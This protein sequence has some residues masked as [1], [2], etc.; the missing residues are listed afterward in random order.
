MEKIDDSSTKESGAATTAAEALVSKN[1]GAGKPIPPQVITVDASNREEE[2]KAAANSASQA[3]TPKHANKTKEGE[4]SATTIDSQKNVTPERSGD[5]TRATATSNTHNF[6]QPPRPYEGRPLG[7]SGAFQPH[8]SR[9][10]QQP[11]PHQHGGPPPHGQPHPDQYYTRSPMQISPGG[12]GAFERIGGYYDRR[13]PGGYPSHH[14]P[15]PPP[16]YYDQRGYND[17]GPPPPMPRPPPHMQAFEQ[18]Q[19]HRG[20]Y[21]PPPYPPQSYTGFQPD[22]RSAYGGH[23]PQAYPPSGPGQYPPG[24][25]H[26]ARDQ[27]YPQEHHGVNSTFSRAVSSSFDR[28]VKEKIAPPGKLSSAQSGVATKPFS[29]APPLAEHAPPG[30]ASMTSDDLSWKQLKQVHSIDDSAIQ[31]HLGLKKRQTPKD[32]DDDEEDGER[33]PPSNSSSLTN[34]PTEGPVR[35]AKVAEAIVAAAAAAAARSQET[36]QP[37]SSSL[38]E[39]SSVASAQAPMDTLHSKSKKPGKPSPPSPGTE[40]SGSLDLMKCS[41]DSSALLQLAAHRNEG[42]LF[43]GKRSRDE[44]RGDS[45]TGVGTEGDDTAELRRA[46]SDLDEKQPLKKVR[47]ERKNDQEDDQARTSKITGTK[48]KTSPLSI[49]CSPSATVTKKSSDASLKVSSAAKPKADF[50][51]SP[52][53]ENS[54]YDKPPAYSYSLDSAPSI[55]RDNGFKRKQQASPA[56]PPRP[57]S[58]S[59]SSLT[60]GHMQIDNQDP[61]NAVVASIPSWEIHAQDSFGAG[62]VGGGHGLANN[63]SF[64]DY[65]MLSASESNLGNAIETAGAGPPHVPVPGHGHGGVPQ[66][67]HMPHP[68]IESRNQSFDGGH[69]HG[70]GS[71]HRSDSMDMSYNGRPGGPGPGPVYPEGPYKHGHVGPFPPHAP[72]WGTAGSGGSHPSYQGHPPGHHP[73]PGRMGE[74]PIM[75]N[76]S[77]DSGHRASPPPGPGVPGRHFMHRPPAG[78]Q[79]PPEFVAPHNPHLNRRPPPA[80]YIMS[81]QGTHHP[82]AQRG[83]G[84]FSWS[85]ED[86]IRL[87]EIMKKYKNPRDWEPVAKELGTG[88]T[89][90]ECHERWI[91]YLKPGVRKGQWTDQEDAIVIEAVTTSSEQPFTRW[92]DL[93]QRLPGRVGKQIRDR[94]VNHL[95]PNINHLPFSREDDLLLWDGHKKLG[96]R[97]VEISTKFFNCSRSE[98]HIK[99][100]WYSASF[101]KFISNEFGQEAYSGGKSSKGKDGSSGKKKTKK[102]D[103]DP[104]THAVGA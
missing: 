64:Q 66:H 49:T 6:P 1:A 54:F 97:W 82:A 74:Y 37:P 5:S 80:V 41:S 15:P 50:H 27:G 98:N 39:L 16:A 40:D 90:K 72:S 103:D 95:N 25:D 20:Q 88:K 86:D 52:Y 12:P 84:V 48:T 55:P 24:P 58:S 57:G 17:Y 18:H 83:T 23:A 35:R 9:R 19:H 32:D 92:S 53:P 62:S 13:G 33:H 56:L 70:G 77:Q 76:Y 102:E 60:P 34:S 4:R 47:I 11:P 91:R 87:T 104:A 21:P 99:N 101:K 38:D 14:A 63:F 51:T 93:A 26:Y 59:S 67:N 10:Q 69:Y 42:L 71:F 22:P 68:P 65:P 7:G 78:F 75:R 46:P 89:A 94:W 28:S 29:P 73:Y 31:E 100:R 8:E 85:K 61:S 36:Q 45:N 2:D 44:E 79:P 3:R 43:D 96:K 81:S 30:D